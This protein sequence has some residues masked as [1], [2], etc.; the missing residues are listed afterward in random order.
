MKKWVDFNALEVY[1]AF[2]LEPFFEVV[3][4]N[5]IP[6]MDRWMDIDKIQ[7]ANQEIANTNYRLNSYIDDTKE[8][9]ERL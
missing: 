3:Q 7:N 8:L 6:F 5:P 1:N 2:E 9:L 4:E